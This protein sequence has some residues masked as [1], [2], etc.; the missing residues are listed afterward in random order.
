MS[1]EEESVLDY[2]FAEE[3]K[4][5]RLLANVIHEQGGVTQDMEDLLREIRENEKMINSDCKAGILSSESKSSINKKINISNDAAIYENEIS[6]EHLKI[7]ARIYFGIVFCPNQDQETINF[8]QKL[9]LNFPLETVLKTF[10][11]ILLEAN[12]K[13]LTEHYQAAK[14]LFD[15]TTEMMN[16]QYRDIALMTTGFS[17][18]EQYPHLKDYKPNQD[19]QSKNKK[20]EFQTIHLNYFRAGFLNIEGLINHPLH[21]TGNINSAFIPFCSFGS[22]MELLGEE[23][24][25]F[26]VPVCR[27]FSEKIVNGQVCYEADLNQFR[28]KV[29][30]E[31]ALS[32]G[33]NLIIDTNDEYDVKNI[34]EKNASEKKKIG[35]SFNSYKDKKKDSSF[36]VMVKTISKNIVLSSY[37]FTN[38]IPRS[39]PCYTGRRGPLC[40]DSC[41]G[42]QGDGGVCWVG[43]DHYQVSDQRVPG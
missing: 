24:A 20:E 14:T 15:K 38:Y 8:Y 19:L 27:L 40:P 34:V 11:R 7:A 1:S 22:S 26:H 9:F 18:L 17:D 29:K 32:S 21:I 33:L 23:L 25:N 36:T 30:W 16:L 12:E 10:T 43:G 2:R 39:C 3:N 6:E 31:E 5:F 42:Y 35:K 28:D 13:K 4:Y 41:E 37:L